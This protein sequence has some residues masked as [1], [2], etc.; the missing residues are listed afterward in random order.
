MEKL[1]QPEAAVLEVGLGRWIE[2]S[3]DTYAVL[4]PIIL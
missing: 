2:E 3:R 4:N 1:G